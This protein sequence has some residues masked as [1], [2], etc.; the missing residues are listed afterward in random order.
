MNILSIQ[1]HVAYGHV[2]NAAAL[3][4]LVTVVLSL[5]QGAMPMAELT[6]PSGPWC[7]GIGGGSGL[8]IGAVLTGMGV[9]GAKG[10]RL[11][12]DAGCDTLAQDPASATVS[13]APK[14]A[15]A[16]EAV[17]REVGLHDLCAEV[18]KLCNVG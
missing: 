17:Q 7:L 3:F 11:M 12:R 14:A 5:A 4:P 2:G 1:S 13:E 10:L 16:A 9:D 18:L 15:I 8:A 6:S